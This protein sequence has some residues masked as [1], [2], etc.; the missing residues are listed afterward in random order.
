[1]HPTSIS[2][3]KNHSII[4]ISV[5]NQFNNLSHGVLKHVF[6]QNL[7]LIIGLSQTVYNSFIIMQKHI[8]QK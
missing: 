3:A 7:P 2:H 8:T 6:V 5:A 1:M 4:I